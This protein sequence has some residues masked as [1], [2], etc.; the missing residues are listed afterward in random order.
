MYKTLAVQQRIRDKGNPPMDF[1]TG[2]SLA[3]LPIKT[4]DRASWRDLVVN[5]KY[6]TFR[7]QMYIRIPTMNTGQEM[8]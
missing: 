4:K 3:E 8:K 1:P 5:I 7:N 6:C 2:L